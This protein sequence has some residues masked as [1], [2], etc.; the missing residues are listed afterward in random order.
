ML[1]EPERAA[2]V[3]AQRLERRAA[4]REALVVRRDHG[5]RRVDD[6]EP[7]DR[8][9]EGATL[10][11][12]R[13][14]G[15]RA[16]RSG[17]GEPSSGAP[18]ASS[19]GAALTSDS[20]TSARGSESQ[21]MPPPTQRWIRPSA[22]ANVRIVSASS[23]SPFPCTRPSAP[24]DAP[25]PTGSSAAMRSTAAIFGA[26]VTDPPGNSR[27]EELRETDARAGAL[28]RPSRPGARRPRGARAPSARASARCPGTQ[29]RERSLRSRSTIITCSAASF[30]EARSSARPPRG[31]VPLIGLVQTR[32]PRRARKSSGEAETIAQPSP[33]SSRHA[34][35]PSGAS[36]GCVRGPS[37]EAS[38][39]GRPANGAERCWTRLTW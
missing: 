6:A 39:A 34:L 35:S 10:T 11:G 23:R 22:I 18:I 2:A 13:L 4:A 19:S 9:R 25:R 38:A 15:A 24:I 31:R 1:P 7:G 27:S 29:T 16:P 32:R 26:P 28:P 3:H 5:L 21:T 30:A 37:R 14:R 12:D 17:R 8:G 33:S 20:S 36:F